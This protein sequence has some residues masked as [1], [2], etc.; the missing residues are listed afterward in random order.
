MHILL[1][2]QAYIQSITDYATVSSLLALF[3]TGLLFYHTGPSTKYGCC[4]C[5]LSAHTIYNLTGCFFFIPCQII[6]LPVIKIF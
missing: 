6:L 3:Q 4:I 5:V 2:I 1:R